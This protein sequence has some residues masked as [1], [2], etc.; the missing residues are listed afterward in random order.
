MTPNILFPFDINPIN[1]PCA[2]VRL[3]L[4]L[5]L[6]TVKNKFSTHTHVGTLFITFSSDSFG[7]STQAVVS[8]KSA[9]LTSDVIVGALGKLIGQTLMFQIGFWNVF[10]REC[11][12]TAKEYQ[13][14][15]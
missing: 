2:W 3:I 7:S 5:N 9:K 1:T 14:S 8:S 13:H 6:R 15:S 12:R 10:P 11:S 4:V